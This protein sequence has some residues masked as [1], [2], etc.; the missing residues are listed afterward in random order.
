MENEKRHPRVSPHRISVDWSITRPLAGVN[1]QKSIQIYLV[2][3]HNSSLTEPELV[4]AKSVSIVAIVQVVAVVT[5]DRD[6][7]GSFRGSIGIT[8][9][10][11]I[12]NPFGSAHTQLLS[13]LGSLYR[14]HRVCFPG[15]GT[16]LKSNSC[17]VTT[18]RAKRSFG[19]KRFILCVIAECG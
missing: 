12:G 7:S 19:S 17:S 11:L 4:F 8:S 13:E 3:P 18:H 15:L 5:F 10:V 2:D 6:V 9:S 1:F 16:I 14:L